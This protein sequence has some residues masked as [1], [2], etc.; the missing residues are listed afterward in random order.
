MKTYYN[1]ITLNFSYPPQDI[2]KNITKNSFLVAVAKHTVHT[3]FFILI[4]IYKAFPNIHDPHYMTYLMKLKYFKQ[5]ATN[6][7]YGINLHIFP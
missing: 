5:H 1:I 3:S 7:G 6:F 2:A 4:H